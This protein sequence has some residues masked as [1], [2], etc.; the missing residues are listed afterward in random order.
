MP[1]NSRILQTVLIAGL[2]IPVGF[3][4]CGR[5]T[6]G[7][8]PAVD[9]SRDSRIE[10]PQVESPATIGP[11]IAVS[12]DATTERSTVATDSPVRIY[13]PDDKRTRHDDARLA[14][15]GVHAFESRHL[16]PGSTTLGY[17]LRIV[18]RKIFR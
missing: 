1:R 3:I 11:A 18:N 6:V 17:C 9:E 13:R 2:L 12:D 5:S 14:A 7:P 4:A 15:A 16:K 8:T 10:S